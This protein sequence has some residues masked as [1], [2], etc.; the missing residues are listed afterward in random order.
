MARMATYTKD[1]LKG[2]PYLVIAEMRDSPL[3]NTPV[4]K[5]PWN[6]TFADRNAKKAAD[7]AIRLA[8]RWASEGLPESIK[9]S[10]GTVEALRRV[11][12]ICK[13][14]RMIANVKENR[15]GRSV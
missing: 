6:S 4:R 5:N 11:G 1:E 15:R 8:K 3:W 7:T 2:L 9:I 10:P 14:L 12:A 13:D